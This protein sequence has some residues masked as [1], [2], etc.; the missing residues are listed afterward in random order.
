MTVKFQCPNCN[1]TRSINPRILGR[2]I[3]C[4]SCEATILLP[5]QEEIDES[6]A[7]RAEEIRRRKLEAQRL[8]AAMVVESKVVESTPVPKQ[9]EE[10]DDDDAPMIERRQMPHDHIDMTPMVDIT[11]LLLIFFM[12]TANFTL[13]KSM[14]VPVK[15]DDKAS[16][17]AIVNPTEVQDSVTVQIDEF[18]GYRVK[19]G[20]GTERDAPSKQ[21][22]INVLDEAKAASVNI[23]APEK[24]IVEA[25]RNCKHATVIGALDAGREKDFSK[26]Q[27]SV[28]D[29]LD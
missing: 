19:M 23:D 15:K 8:A 5:S 22:L 10:E 17:R 2:E 28:V 12:S 13:Q 6:R 4:P 14:E 3:R 7:M 11:F 1:E 18:N 9:V 21:D 27:V 26:F 16:T 20:D 25:H 24:L 29:E